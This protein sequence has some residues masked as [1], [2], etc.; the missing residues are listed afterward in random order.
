[1]NVLLLYSSG[2]KI[3]IPVGVPPG[4]LRFATFQ[5]SWHNR[6]KAQAH[7]GFICFTEVQKCEILA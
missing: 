5:A 1:M 6:Q 7:V 3:A 4:F 2:Q